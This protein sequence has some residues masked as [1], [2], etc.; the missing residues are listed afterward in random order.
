M[1]D[2]VNEAAKLAAHGEEIL[3]VDRQLMVSD[4]FHSNLNEHNKNLLSW[5]YS[6][7]CWHGDVINLEMEKWREENCQ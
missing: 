7:Q 3:L 6:R 1:G 5:S 2:V 4:A